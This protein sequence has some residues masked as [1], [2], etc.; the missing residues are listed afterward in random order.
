MQQSQIN[1]LA[2]L[3]VLLL[4]YLCTT[5]HTYFT[6]QPWLLKSPCPIPWSVVAP[7]VVSTHRIFLL[8]PL[9]QLTMSA[10]CDAI[11]VDSNLEA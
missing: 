2:K 8:F 4:L 10:L 6:K 5:I 1:D 3:Y 7:G 9:P 11:G